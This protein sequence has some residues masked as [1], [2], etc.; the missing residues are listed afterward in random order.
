MPNKIDKESNNQRPLFGCCPWFLVLQ[1]YRR[2][3]PYDL[4]SKKV[5]TLSG[6][7]KRK[8]VIYNYLQMRNIAVKINSLLTNDIC[9]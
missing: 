1:E 3:F 9:C 6:Q 2:Y 5:G 7:L 4:K 8:T